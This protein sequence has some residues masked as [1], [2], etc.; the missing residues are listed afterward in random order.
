MLN[1]AYFSFF[2][3]FVFFTETCKTCYSKTHRQ[4]RR[5]RA[6]LPIQ[7]VRRTW[8][9][10]GIKAGTFR[11]QTENHNTTPSSRLQVF[12]TKHRRNLQKCGVTH[13]PQD[14][15][16][17]KKHQPA[18]TASLH[19]CLSAVYMSCVRIGDLII[20]GRSM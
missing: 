11:T 12:L 7:H 18:P 16:T 6:T 14:R 19:P 1:R 15:D 20:F 4:P 17:H 10:P 9:A 8:A 13:R 3:F 2:V 5:S